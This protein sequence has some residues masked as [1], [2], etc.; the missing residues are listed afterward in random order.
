MADAKEHLRNPEARSRLIDWYPVI[1]KELPLTLA[2]LICQRASLWW[3]LRQRDRVRGA[4]TATLCV[5][6]F[7][8]LLIALLCGNTV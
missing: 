8:I 2:R 7:A 5:L 3:D 4:L 6:A 1:V